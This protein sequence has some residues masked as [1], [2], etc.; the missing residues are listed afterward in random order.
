M[1]HHHLSCFQEAPSW[2]GKAHRARCREHQQQQLCSGTPPPLHL[3][4][5]DIYSNGTKALQQHSSEQSSAASGCPTAVVPF[6]LGEKVQC[7]ALH[8]KGRLCLAVV[9]LTTTHQRS[10]TFLVSSVFLIFLRGQ[11]IPG[12]GGQGGAAVSCTL[13]CIK[14]YLETSLAY[15]DVTHVVSLLDY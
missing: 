10:D 1:G 7:I 12:R 14:L 15:Q 9:C 8:L 5:S 2:T 4:T 13:V 3:T 6:V 11:C